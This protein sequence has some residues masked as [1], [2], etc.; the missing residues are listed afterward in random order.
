M[1]LPSF[2]NPA[3][4]ERPKKGQSV[5]RKCFVASGATVHEIAVPLHL[6]GRL[7]VNCQTPYPTECQTSSLDGLLIKYDLLTPTSPAVV[8]LLF[9]GTFAREKYG[10]VVTRKGHRHIVELRSAHDKALEEVDVLCA[11][12]FLIYLDSPEP[13]NK[14][15]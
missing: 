3:L 6:P 1:L 4:T 5:A 12:S 10:V 8:N 9:R 13:P 2:L 11:S 7:K 14:Q 15:I